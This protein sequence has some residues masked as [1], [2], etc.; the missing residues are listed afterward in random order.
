[1]GVGEGSYREFGINN[2]Y[3]SLRVIGGKEKDR[4][5]YSL[6]YTVWCSGEHELY[7]HITDAGQ[8]NNLL[9]TES[10]KVCQTLASDTHTFAVVAC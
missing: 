8:M 2:T 9:L 10:N 4:K 3:K 6:S 1:M 7:D 5:G